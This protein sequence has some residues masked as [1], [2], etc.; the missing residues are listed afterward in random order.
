M[1][2]L[3]ILASAAIVALAACTKTEVVYTEAPAEIGFK[4]FTGAM[5]KAPVTDATFPTEQTMFVYGWNNDGKAKYFE[6]NPTEFAYDNTKA[7]WDGNTAQYYPATGALDFV[8][9][10]QA[11]SANTDHLTYT[12]TLADNTGAQHD[13]M[14]S[15]Y[16]AGK[17]KGD[18]TV[19]L[20]FHHTLSLVQVNFKCTGT[21]VQIKSVALTDT[22]QAGT[23]TVTYATADDAT[24]PTVVWA[25][26]GEDKT[27]KNDTGASLTAGAAS[28]EY[29][30]FLAVPEST[31]DKQLTIE[32]ILNGNT[33]THP[34]DIDNAFDPATKYVFDITIGMAE[35]LFDATV[36]DW[37]PETASPVI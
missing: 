16:V 4:A 25:A 31:N 20:P 7:A 27:L 14:A 2:R 12:L 18:G 22:K 30:Y 9:F 19:T 23:A 5:T 17:K 26:S 8:A 13:L 32:Y 29:A 24:E 34:I 3:F 37:T 21:N 15:A 36:V 33:F 35:V 6:P 1:K 10:T 28:A 11:P